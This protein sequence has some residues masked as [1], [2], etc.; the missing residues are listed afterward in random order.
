MPFFATDKYLTDTAKFWV[1]VACTVPATG[2]AFAIYYYWRWRD[3]QRIKRL[4]GKSRKD[5]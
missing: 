2:L 4:E 5:A 1:W 3:K